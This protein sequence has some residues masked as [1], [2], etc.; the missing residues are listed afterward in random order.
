MRDGPEKALLERYRERLNPRLDVLEVPEGRGAA[1]EIKRREAQAILGALPGGALL[2]ALDE[3][4]EAMNSERLA[5]RL[6]GWLGSGRTLCFAVG[7][8]EGLDA[9][10]L[11]R[12]DAA[13]SLGAMTWP[14]MLVRPML[15]EQLYR[16]RCIATGH[17]YHRAGRP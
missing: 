11:A 9:A 3:C 17:P 2:V 7:G 12:A 15:A 10:V 16:A 14:H 13:L 1:A 5:R 4:G 8:A 6:D